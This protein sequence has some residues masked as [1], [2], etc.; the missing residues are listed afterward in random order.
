ML[1]IWKRELNHLENLFLRHVEDRLARLP[2]VEAEAAARREALAE[3]YRGI[4]NDM[5]ANG[6]EVTVETVKAEYHRRLDLKIEGILADV[7]M[8]QKGKRR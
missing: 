1:R 2:A 4:V 6:E 7:K 5:R 8:L 3:E